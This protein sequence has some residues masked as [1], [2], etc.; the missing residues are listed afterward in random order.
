VGRFQGITL[1]DGEWTNNYV[2]ARNVKLGLAALLGAFA[3]F[4]AKKKGRGGLS[5]LSAGAAG[6]LLATLLGNSAPVRGSFLTN[7]TG[8]WLGTPASTKGSITGSLA[9]A[10]AFNAALSSALGAFL[11][12]STSEIDKLMYA[13]ECRRS[14]YSG[15]YDSAY[16]AQLNT[17]L[18]LQRML[19]L[20]GVT[21]GGRYPGVCASSGLGL[22][23]CV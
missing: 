6:V 4:S 7:G 21:N 11:S 2:T 14:T 12:S 13:L 5:A 3:L 22:G 17:D 9:E 10:C 15:V 20:M 23:R 18:M 16:E 19:A 8:G 1:I